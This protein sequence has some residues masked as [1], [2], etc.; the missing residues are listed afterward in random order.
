M[1]E[2]WAQTQKEIVTDFAEDGTAFTFT[3]KIKKEYDPIEGKYEEGSDILTFTSY[4]FIKNKSLIIQDGARYSDGTLIQAS[5]IVVLLDGTN[6]IRIGDTTE[7]DGQKV[8]VA[9]VTCSKPGG[10]PL[11]YTIALRA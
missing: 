6:P 8:S 7:L 3:R 9:S 4:G 5:D 1:A 10:I 2:D 11:T